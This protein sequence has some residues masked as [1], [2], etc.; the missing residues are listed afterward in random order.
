MNLK[1][2]RIGVPFILL[3]VVWGVFSHANLVSAATTAAIPTATPSAKTKIAS[4]SA[5]QN[6]TTVQQNIK[7]RIEKILDDKGSSVLNS[8]K[9]KA[10][11]GQVVRVT[12]ESLT[13]NTLHGEVTVKLTPEKTAMFLMPRLTPV[14]ISDVEIDGFVIA[15]GY[16]DGDDVLDARRVLVSPAPLFP[17]KKG[18]ILGT[19]QSIKPTQLLV[20]TLAQEDKTISLSSK[21]VYQDNTGTAIKR[22]DVKEDTKILVITPNEDD[23]S[24]SASLVRVMR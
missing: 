10:Y 14:Q 2:Y 7:D 8:L 3:F 22:T 16:V 15:M 1:Q 17:I 23:A 11:V 9:R 4:P 12:T 20:R 18:V 5:D 19:V 6:N 24:A 21:T 13:V